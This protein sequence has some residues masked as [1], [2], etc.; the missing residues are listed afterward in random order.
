M[1]K[2]FV[3]DHLEFFSMKWD[4]FLKYWYF[5]LG[6]VILVVLLIYYG[7]YKLQE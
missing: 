7:L 2:T 3:I 4:L 6:F 5:Y 1:I